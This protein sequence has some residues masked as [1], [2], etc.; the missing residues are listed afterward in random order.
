MKKLAILLSLLTPI[1]FSCHKEKNEKIN[2][3]IIFTDDQGYQDVGVFGSPNIL[4][5]NLDKLASEGTML[6]NYYA[7][8]P[9]CSAGPDER[10]GLGRQSPDRRIHRPVSWCGNKE[11]RPVRGGAGVDLSI[12]ASRHTVTRGGKT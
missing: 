3:V 11:N 7:G 4:T 1:L 12:D 2:V 10:P 9:V 6:T 5:P 8:Q